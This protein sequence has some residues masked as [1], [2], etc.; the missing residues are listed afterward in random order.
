[1]VY[2]PIECWTDY[3]MTKPQNWKHWSLSLVSFSRY[4]PVCDC[5]AGGLIYPSLQHVEIL[6]RLISIAHDTGT[7]NEAH[8]EL[9]ILLP[10]I[11]ETKDSSVHDVLL[12]C[13]IE[14]GTCK[15]LTNE[16]KW[17]SN[18]AVSRCRGS[19]WTLN[20]TTTTRLMRH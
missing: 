10:G 19:F 1:M 8:Y 16:L 14:N 6:I 4:I 17:H 2:S 12:Q 9:C 7:T 13:N 5:F 3:R 18:W 11:E 15:V 20:T